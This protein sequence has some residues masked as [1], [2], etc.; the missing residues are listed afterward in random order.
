MP[1]GIATAPPVMMVPRTGGSVLGYAPYAPVPVY[2][3]PYPP[4]QAAPQISADDLKMV[5][6]GKRMICLLF[7]V[8]LK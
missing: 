2:Q 7:K 6:A 5:I 1:Y 3:T 4:P 8:T